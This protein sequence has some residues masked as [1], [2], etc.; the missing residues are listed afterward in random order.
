MR[1]YVVNVIQIIHTL[2][3]HIIAT[4]E[5]LYPWM[6]EGFT[7]YG[8]TRIM[9]H[10]KK[11]GFLPG[12]PEEDPFASNYDRYAQLVHAG[13]E[14]PLTTHADHYHTN[15]AYGVAAYVKGA[16]FLRQLEYIL[17]KETFRSEEHKS[18][19]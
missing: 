2:N 16:I 10:L 6:N 8:S 5:S 19:L 12:E 18:K 3:K 9:N 15:V 1:C 14:E 11:K 7:S 4:N 13:L 17:G